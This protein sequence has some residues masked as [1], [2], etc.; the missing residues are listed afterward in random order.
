MQAIR[1]LIH[2]KT[3]QLQISLPMDYCGMDVEVIILPSTGLGNNQKHSKSSQEQFSLSDFAGCWQGKP[4]T[5]D[6][7]EEYE[8]RDELW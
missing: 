7:Q 4:L 6:I 1:E 8:A 3:N 2:L 5:R